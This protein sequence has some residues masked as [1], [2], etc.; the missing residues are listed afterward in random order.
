MRYEAKSMLLRK[1]HNMSKITIFQQLYSVS[2]CSLL[3]YWLT[4][5]H[6]PKY[7]IKLSS[8]PAFLLLKPPFLNPNCFPFSA[9]LALTQARSHSNSHSLLYSLV[10]L[11]FLSIDALTILVVLK[12]LHITTGLKDCILPYLCTSFGFGF[13]AVGFGVSI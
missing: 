10:F 9:H 5:F 6:H 4:T 7:N 1:H 8:K 3:P 2:L 13:Q 11:F 12:F